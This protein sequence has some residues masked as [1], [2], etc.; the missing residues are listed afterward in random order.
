VILNDHPTSY[1]QTLQD[2]IQTLIRS[3]GLQPLEDKPGGVYVRRSDVM[4]DEDRIL[5]HTVAR[6]VLVT[7]RGT[8]EEQLRAAD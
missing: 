4:P 2:G 6:V 8:L 7:E 3:T 5:L 1:F